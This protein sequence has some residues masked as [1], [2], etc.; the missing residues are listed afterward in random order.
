MAYVINR[1]SGQ[2]LVVLEDGTLDTSTSIGLL[3]RNYVGY[4]EV[5]NENFLFL[6]ENFAN[7]D[8]PSR[9]IAGQTWY[10]TL[11]KS[12]N[13][14]TGE[15][16]G[17]VGTAIVD[18]SEPTGFDGGLWYKSTTD[19][20][21]VYR[22]GIWRLVGPEAVEGAG[23]TRLR[24]RSLL[25][26]NNVN[27]AVLELVVDG[28]TL[29][30]CANE[31]FVINPT[32]FIVGFND[33]LEPGI[34]VA[35]TR[36]FAGSLI[37]N[38]TSASILNPG[39]LING[40][41]FDGANNITI[42]SSTTNILSRGVYLTGTNFDGS[43]ATTWSVDAT[44]DNIIGKVVARDSAG[45]FSAG[46]IT[47]NLSG[48]LSGNVNST[49][50]SIFNIVQANEFV[51]A[52]LS[53]NAFTATKLQDAR[54]INGVLFD[55]T[56]NINV[57]V[58]A[59][60][61]TGSVL[62]SNVVET[63]ITTVGTL[64]NLDI[65]SGGSFTIGGPSSASAPFVALLETG[66]TPVLSGTTGTIKIQ[67]NDL[68][69]PNLKTDIALVNSTQALTLG[70]LSAPSL[71]PKSNGVTNLGISTRKWNNVYANFFIGTATQAQY[72]DLAENYLAD[73][74][75][76]PGTV[77]EFGGKFEVTLAEDETKKIAGV[78]STNPAHLMN[79]KLQ[80]NHVVAVALQG[81]VPCKVRGRI[82]KGD[83]LVSGG[84][85]YARPTTDPKIGTILGK[86]L[87][88]FDGDSGLI[89]VV[90]GRI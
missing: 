81:R 28:T 10:N 13:I 1:F 89:E 90:V 15:E 32:N 42:K 78:V 6:L 5:Q 61:I 80:G 57:P 55:G 24:A 76:E 3:G 74:Y 67:I 54:T 21:F 59:S 38:S 65:S 62:A 30:I 66:V 25:D 50:T 56:A 4:G 53:G 63:A 33:E 48:N 71:L 87:E 72:A 73:T 68:S 34:N 77:L 46:T 26:S 47:A 44:P 14:Y 20:L 37:G 27:H 60:S 69:Q 16:W 23:T 79:S 17:P 52:T 84:N 12:L 31:Q 43:S 36:N 85:G 19:Q 70:G 83:M 82:R 39:R 45:N 40:V 22:D 75:Y 29:A 88:D 49:G 2:Q 86:S 58:P 9:P 7:E 41:F 11:T 8:P 64:S 18:N 35:S 51:G